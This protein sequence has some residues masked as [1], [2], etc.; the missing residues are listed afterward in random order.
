MPRAKNEY[1]AV[2]GAEKR[3]REILAPMGE[4]TAQWAVEL[5]TGEGVTIEHKPRLKS[6]ALTLPI[7][8]PA[9]EPKLGKFVPVEPR[10]DAHPGE[11]DD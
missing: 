3:L 2:A 9:P 1:T 7:P 11:E 8:E 5:L 10:D 4:Q 6:I